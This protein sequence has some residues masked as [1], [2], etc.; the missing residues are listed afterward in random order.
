MK[1]DKRARWVVFFMGVILM[2][3]TAGCSSEETSEPASEPSTPTPSSQEEPA[4]PPE[5]QKA[6]PPAVGDNVVARTKSSGTYYQGKVVNL[7]GTTYRVQTNAYVEPI[8]AN[9]SDV[10]PMPTAESPTV[11]AVRDIV[12]VRGDSE[13]WALGEVT[14]VAAGVVNVKLL[15][16]NS[17]N[18]VPPQ[19][20][21][22]IN[23]AAAANARAEASAAQAE[24]S[25][26]TES[27]EA[28]EAS[29]GDGAEICQRAARCCAAAFATPGLPPMY[30]NRREQACN[31][32]NGATDADFCR[33][34]IGGWRQMVS[35][36]PNATVP[37]DCAAE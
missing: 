31:A 5:A 8:Q 4:S 14:G 21:I 7:D 6:A 26:A 1:V 19:N 16:N 9:A 34:A 18:N 28:P 24:D 33:T 2:V 13:S 22:K 30:A 10:Y 20:L 37:D 35:A 12:A 23:P 25:A 11:V 17:T 27:A 32:V 36:L 3:W 15:E 29:G